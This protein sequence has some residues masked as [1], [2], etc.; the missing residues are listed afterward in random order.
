LRIDAFLAQ[1]VVT[2]PALRP[3]A[4]DLTAQRAFADVNRASLSCVIVAYVVPEYLHGT[5]RHSIQ[6]TPIHLDD[7]ETMLQPNDERKHGKPHRYS[8]A[9]KIYGPQL[10]ERKGELCAQ[11]AEPE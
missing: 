3:F 6:I 11:G 4:L 7:I 1:F 10:W 2:H 5:K 8:A 9:T